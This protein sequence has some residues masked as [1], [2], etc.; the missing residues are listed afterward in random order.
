MNTSWDNEKL[1]IGLEGRID[2]GNA[3]DVENEINEVMKDKDPSGLVLDAEGLEYISSAG[4]RVILRLRK[5]H[6][7]MDARRSGAELTAAYTVSTRIM[8]LKY[9]T[10]PTRLTISSMNAKSPGWH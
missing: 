5:K 7:V 3:A 9:I 10:T 2:S 6:P 1:T 4:L 8:S